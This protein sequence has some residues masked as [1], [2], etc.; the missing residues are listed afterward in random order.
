M[1]MGGKSAPFGV[2]E[3]DLAILVDRLKHEPLLELNGIHLFLGT[4]NLDSK[5]LL[6]QY[7]RGVDLAKEVAIKM[8]HPLNTI[9]FG[10]GFGIPYFPRD[11]VLN[12]DHFQVG[13]ESM[14]ERIGNDPWLKETRFMVEPGR[15]LVGEAGIYL[16]RINDIKVSRGKKYLVVDGGMHHHLAASGNFG[17]TIKRNFPIAAVNKLGRTKAE[18][19]DI[20]GPLCTPLDVLGRG[21][22]LPTMEVGDIIGIFQSGAYARTSSPLQ[23]LMHPTPPEVWIFEGADELIRRRSTF[24]DLLYDI[25]GI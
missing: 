13:L 12:L 4:Q 24:D 22:E 17:Q 19:V 21:V 25:V 6:D 23:F 1:R 18:K 16:M 2:D 9:D 20:V 10:G 3:E 15:F 11:E 7:Q 5:V 14:L 8:Q